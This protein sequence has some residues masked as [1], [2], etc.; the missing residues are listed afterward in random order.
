VVFAK[1]G[2]A[3]NYVLEFGSPP[4]KRA[5]QADVRFVSRLADYA[6][7]IRSA[8]GVQ[9]RSAQVRG[10]ADI[11]IEVQSDFTT[12]DPA[13]FEI[14]LTAPAETLTL[15][16]P[17]GQV[18]S[19]GPGKSPE[20]STFEERY[21]SRDAGFVLL[22]AIPMDGIHHQ[23]SL[24]NTPKGRYVVHIESA[25][26]RN[27]VVAF[28]PLKEVAKVTGQKFREVP[29]VLRPQP[30]QVNIDVQLLPFE[31]FAGDRLAV[32]AKL[33]GDIGSKAPAFAARIQTQRPLSVVDRWMRYAD[34]GPVETVPLKMVREADGAWHGPVMLDKPGISQVSL[35]VSGE[36][37][38]GK[39]FSEE[40]LLTNSTINVYPIVARLL[41]VVAKPVD[42]DGRFERLDITAEL[43]VSYPGN[44]GFGFSIASGGRKLTPPGS[45]RTALGRGRQTI[46]ASLSG[47]YVWGELKDGPFVIADVWI[48][49]SEDAYL[50]KVPA[51]DIQVRTET[52]KRDQ[53]NPGNLFGDDTITLHGIQP[54]SSGRFQFAEVQWAVTTPG[55]QCTWNGNLR[56]SSADFGEGVDY[57]GSL[58]AGRTTLSFIF[59]GALI[60]VPDK[61]DWSFGAV[62]RCGSDETRMY[63]PEHGL[64]PDPA[65]YQPAQ[66]SFSV[67]L[68]NPIRISAGGS[69]S[70]VV[71]I[72]NA[73]EQV[74]FSFGS[75][76]TGL[77][78]RLSSPRRRD[79]SVE[80]G[81]D[82]KA[83]PDAKPG[84]YVIEISAESE[85]ETARSELL[86]DVIGQ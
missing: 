61:H 17:S 3:G 76:P 24:P 32:V 60:A 84:R 34:P 81:V 38:S 9:I 62:I 72:P 16:S 12:E 5:A 21:P 78:M 23:I 56:G 13:F 79:K 15:T 37:A 65:E 14:A 51:T 57:S 31:C 73:P 63:T 52:W 43:D 22:W 7:Q 55:G 4:L 35:R 41:S 33:P 18:L 82:V 11:P 47:R 58:A 75:V 44:Y 39:P 80:A 6:G 19:I 27:V 74:Q 68:T 25:Q 26:T 64:A 71:Y 29:E 67:H 30:G 69:A 85:T 59:D 48:L 66:T 28:G 50:V 20:Y 1:S 49:R 2:T 70:A 8:P 10:A 53:W 46:T 42:G 83:T 86:V 54:A 45:Q 77:Q 36:T 40:I